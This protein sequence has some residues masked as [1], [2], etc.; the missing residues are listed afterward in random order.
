MPD[1][2]LALKNLR[3]RNYN[4]FHAKIK[5]MINSCDAYETTKHLLEVILD[6]SRINQVGFL[7]LHELAKVYTLDIPRRDAFLAKLGKHGC[8][9]HVLPTAIKTDLPVQKIVELLKP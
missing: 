1:L 7:D 5:Q 8:R 2:R 9:T 3:A 4:A 6:E